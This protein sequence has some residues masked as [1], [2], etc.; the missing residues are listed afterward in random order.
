MTATDERV[1]IAT[2]SPADP[3]RA[4][5]CAAAWSAHALEEAVTVGVLGRTFNNPQHGAIWNALRVLRAKNAPTDA[6]A[7][8][9]EL[10]RQGDRLSLAAIALLPDILSAGT[11]ASTAGY[12]AQTVVERARARDGKTLAMRL[13]Q[14]YDQPDV[15][16]AAIAGL[17][18]EHLEDE[19]AKV[20]TAAVP[21]ID[22]LLSGDDPEHDWLI[23]GLLERGDRLILTGPEGGGKSTFLRQLS[24]MCASGI[25]PF[26]LE[27]ITPLHVL[28]VDLE[29]SRRQTR[30]ETR[31]LRIKVGRQLDPD[32]LHIEVR[33]QGIDLTQAADVDWLH[34]TIDTLKPDL[35][36]TGPV[37]KMA[38]GDP[39]EEK[40]AKPVAMALDRMRA[41]HDVAVLL[42]AHSA[43]APAGQKRRPKEPYGWS[44]WMRWPEFGIHLDD[45]GT[46]THWRGMR[47]QRDWPELLL[48]GGSWPWM[49]ARTEPDHRWAL[50]H[51][52]ITAAGEVPSNRELARLTGIAETSVR[53]LIEAN[54][55]RL[56]ALIEHLGDDTE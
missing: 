41:E 24:V 53:R 6:P 11:L 54:S 38:N 13:G 9:G 37:Y 21:N 14:M 7:L 48:R 44:G 8:L 29:N 50:I 36:V 49:P 42:E 39:N 40:S 2:P 30:R 56:A 43:K 16:H 51:Q 27:P 23:P 22:E 47:E 1:D 3:E 25:H 46:V 33:I 17:L 34:R 15:D 12:H 5:L 52:A 19:E 20:S 31:P 26:L 10:Q 18:R 35:L 45:D 32:N 28:V 55:R 4:L